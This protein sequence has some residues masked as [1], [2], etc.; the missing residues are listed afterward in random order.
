MKKSVTYIERPLIEALIVEEGLTFKEQSGFLKVEANGLRLYPA[1]T[2][3]VGRCDLSGFVLEGKGF[4]PLGEGESFGNVKC[5]VDFSGT[6]EETLEA[7]RLC[8]RTMKEHKAPE[9]PAPR[10]KSTKHDSAPASSPASPPEDRL[11]L[12]QKVAAEMG[13]PVSDSVLAE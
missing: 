9:K 12:I 13:V 8:L 7:I 10:L 1:K 4:T 3:R 2:K 11:A 5:Q 6:Q